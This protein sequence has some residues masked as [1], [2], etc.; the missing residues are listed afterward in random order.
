MTLFNDVGIVRAMFNKLPN[1]IDPIVSVQ[2]DKCFEARVNQGLFPRLIKQTLSQ[3]NDV[4]V[5]I[6]FFYD[7][8]L[9]FPAFEMS[10]ATSLTLEC[11]RSLTAFDYP[12]EAKV[13]GIFVESMALVEDVPEDV[14]IYE[15]SPDEEKIS[16]I[17]LVED[18]LLLC[19]PLAPINE[20]T[21]LNYQS[22]EPQED[23]E[24]QEEIE[25]KPNPFAALKGLRK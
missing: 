9:R 24:P 6:Q 5:S 7:K 12:C 25:T 13:K 18:E 21:E 16:L 8:V 3:E 11:Q 2:H 20:S 17:E 23:L 4:D 15:L 1:L 14:E 22:D 19:I 10:L